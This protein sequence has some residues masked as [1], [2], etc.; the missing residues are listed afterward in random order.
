MHV[1]S[2]R[3]QVSL[4]SIMNG[5]EYDNYL[6]AFDHSKYINPNSSLIGRPTFLDLLVQ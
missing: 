5:H 2:L 1:I 6:L 3:L 4:V